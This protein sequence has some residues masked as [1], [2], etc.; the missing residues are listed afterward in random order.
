M[1]EI[2]FVYLSIAGMV[3]LGVLIAIP[4]LRRQERYWQLLE[5]KLQATTAK[6]AKLIASL[7]G[8]W[9]EIYRIIMDEENS[10]I[11]KMRI[12]N[13]R[14]R[15]NNRLRSTPDLSLEQFKVL[16]GLRTDS[17]WNKWFAD[18]FTGCLQE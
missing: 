8:F 3:L 10:T 5:Q 2:P 18:Y 12:K 6:E 16:Y 13:L 14:S 17:E 9:S 1:I 11:R 15:L 4:I 7:S